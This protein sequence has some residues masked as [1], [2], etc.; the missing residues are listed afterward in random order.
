MAQEK[1]NGYKKGFPKTDYKK[2]SANIEWSIL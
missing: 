2:W 1:K